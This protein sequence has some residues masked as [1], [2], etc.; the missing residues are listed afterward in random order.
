MRSVRDNNHNRQVSWYLPVCRF[1]T[2]PSPPQ[3]IEDLTAQF[4]HSTKIGDTYL[5]IYLTLPQ[6]APTQLIVLRQ[7]N[8]GADGQTCLTLNEGFNFVVVVKKFYDANVCKKEYNIWKNVYEVDVLLTKL[9]DSVLSLCHMCFP[10]LNETVRLTLISIC[11]I[12]QGTQIV[13][14]WMTSGLTITNQNDET[15]S[16]CDVARF[17]C[18]QL[19][20]TYTS[21]CISSTTSRIFQLPEPF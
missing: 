5:D 18:E 19:R 14:C 9:M 11:L 3:I 16:H 12:G 21:V 20:N 4:P 7:F 6:Q 8:G 17:T 2:K 15:N 13:L 1:N 10:V